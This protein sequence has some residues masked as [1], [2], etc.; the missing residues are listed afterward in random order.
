MQRVLLRVESPGNEKSLLDKL[1][2]IVDAA[3]KGK[4]HNETGKAGKGASKGSDADKSSGDGKGKAGKG[5]SKDSDTGKSSGGG[6]GKGNGS[7]EF[8]PATLKADQWH[9]TYVHERNAIDAL[10]KIKEGEHLLA[11]VLDSVPAGLLSYNLPKDA[12][13]SVVLLKAVDCSKA[14]RAPTFDK[15]GVPKVC[16][17]HV[18]QFGKERLVLR[19]QAQE[20][21]PLPAGQPTKVVRVACIKHFVVDAVWKDRSKNFKGS[22]KAWMATLRIPKEDIV[23][24]FAPRRSECGSILSVNVR[25]AA[26]RAA[27][28][29]M[30]SGISGFLSREL[31][32][33]SKT[34]QPCGHIKWMKKKEDESGPELLNRARSEAELTSPCLGLAFSNSGTIGVRSASGSCETAWKV[35]GLPKTTSI[36]QFAEW[37]KVNLWPEIAIH[38]IRKRVNPN[39]ASFVF[40]GANP[41][42][43]NIATTV[44]TIAD[45]EEVF[46]EFEPYRPLVRAKVFKPLKD[47]GL[48]WDEVKTPD[49]SASPGVKSD[50]F[51]EVD[52]TTAKKARKNETG[53][54]TMGTQKEEVLQSLGLTVRSVPSD[55]ACFFHSLGWWFERSSKSMSCPE[56]LRAQTIEH[57]S[58]KRNIFEPI[59]DR[60][61]PTGQPC[62]SWKAYLDIMADKKSWAGELEAL[63][64]ATRWN[65]KIMIVRPGA[66][67][68]VVGQGKAQIW[69]LLRNAHFEPLEPDND[70]SHSQ[71]RKD[72][73]AKV[74]DCFKL[75]TQQ[76][77]QRTWVLRGGGKTT[78]E[79]SGQPSD[80]ATM[81]ARSSVR[82]IQSSA[83]GT[84]RARSSARAG[85][86]CASGTMGAC[87]G[88]SDEP[89][90]ATNLAMSSILSKTLRARS[91]EQSELLVS[92]TMRARPA[93]MKAV[94]QAVVRKNASKV[95]AACIAA[96]KLAEL[97]HMSRGLDC[98]ANSFSKKNLMQM[99]KALKPK[100]RPAA[101]TVAVQDNIWCRVSSEA[102]VKLRGAATALPW[103]CSFVLLRN[104]IKC[105]KCPRQWIGDSK[106][107]APMR[108]CRTSQCV[109]CVTEIPTQAARDASLTQ[110]GLLRAR[111]DKDLAGI[112]RRLE[113][114]GS[115][116][117]DVRLSKY[118][119][120]SCPL[121]MY[122]LPEKTYDPAYTT[123]QHLRAHGAAGRAELRSATSSNDA[124]RKIAF[125]A[126][127]AA[128]VAKR[129]ATREADRRVKH[130]MLDSALPVWAC[131]FG[132]PQVVPIQ[133]G[134]RS[135]CLFTCRGCAATTRSKLRTL[136][137]ARI[138]PEAEKAVHAAAGRLAV[139]ERRALVQ[140][141]IDQI[142]VLD[143]ERRVQRSREKLRLLAVLRRGRL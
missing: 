100:K 53:D 12:T 27:E 124:K 14:V 142:N 90:P 30:A 88:L 131:Q 3:Q 105:Q 61:T 66:S 46:V 110:M 65:L 31:P 63:A 56:A 95:A 127:A 129:C 35:S 23:D 6:R 96:N 13:I 138:C 97:H 128:N 76:V 137:E 34:I 11:G 57:L 87:S 47:G 26:L 64:A 22:V 2:R 50:D 43:A 19:W 109:A 48:S 82:S 72:H 101:A 83:S 106:H 77:V 126:M 29:E 62:T 143:S 119:N 98:A 45:G 139:S 84:L 37:L 20:A 117:Q 94:G 69:I 89:P 52:A 25:V 28:I 67:T 70:P 120:W 91:A 113:G 17:M 79:V 99:A 80:G 55:G 9:G 75:M 44:Q 39:G 4:L 114:L 1:I 86:S 54:S 103:L 74:A 60:Q 7:L 51:V 115:D 93:A 132:C 92:G 33:D 118:A 15:R 125:G 16:T 81:R 104:G 102:A 38:T 121:C 32:S 59:W 5:A 58:K 141:C 85:Q 111:K 135:K 112:K 116:V 107:A 78:S 134:W 42:G 136:L 36:T 8:I 40:R 41:S 73:I 71:V 49:V 122:R 68:V 123:R 10:F 133:N 21:K 140:S 24:I 18:V 108:F 130:E